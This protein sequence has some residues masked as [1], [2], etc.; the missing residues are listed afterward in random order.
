MGMPIERCIA[1]YASSLRIRMPPKFYG[2]SELLAG[3]AL[4]ILAWTIAPVRAPLTSSR[5]G[6][7]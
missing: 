1:E 4:M 2:L 3:L 6:W 7:H 5:G